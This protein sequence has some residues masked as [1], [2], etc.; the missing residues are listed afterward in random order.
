VEADT[1][2]AL[3]KLTRRE[4]LRDIKV[5]LG[6]KASKLLAMGF[7]HSIYRSTLADACESRDWRIWYDFAYSSDRD[8]SI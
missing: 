4:S 6:A 2:M 5:T 1:G 7:S 3:A 8:H